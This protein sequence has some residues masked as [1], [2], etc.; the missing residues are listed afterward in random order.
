MVQRNNINFTFHL[1]RQLTIF[2]H[3]R[4]FQYLSRYVIK[5]LVCFNMVTIFKIYKLGNFWIF[6]AW[7]TSPTNKR[8]K[9]AKGHSIF[10]FQPNNF[11]VSCLMSWR[12]VLSLC[13]CS[14]SLKKNLIQ[15]CDLHLNEWMI[16]WMD[17]A[18]SKSF[19]KLL[20]SFW[21]FISINDN[22]TEANGDICTWYF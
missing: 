11:V 17:F 10:K 5:F 21:H 6:W 20:G 16:E 14:V 2:L 13:T 7:T 15:F 12:R 8:G 22:W 4:C 18:R 3:Y 9:T 19:L 1:H